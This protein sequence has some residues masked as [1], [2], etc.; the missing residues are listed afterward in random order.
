MKPNEL[1][2]YNVD[3]SQLEGV[4]ENV[5]F[6]ESIEEVQR[7][8]SNSKF[9]IVPRGGGSNIVG[10]CIPQNSI[11][12][13]LKKMNKVLEFD[14]KERSVFAEAGVTIKELNEKLKAVG[15]EFPIYC[16]DISTIGGMVARGEIGEMAMKYGPIKEWVSEIELVNGRGEIVK[17]GKA[18][19]SEVYGMEG[20][21]GVIVK[22]KLGITPIT[23][24]SASIFQTEEIEEIWT[25]AKRL[26]LE[27]EIVVL[28]LLN[29]SV[30]EIFGF[31][32]RYNLIVIF[33]SNRGK[34][35]GKNFKDLLKKIRKES[36]FL[37][38]KSYF[39]SL[40]A[41]FYFD[42]LK[43]FVF[44]L[45]NLD[46]PYLGDLGMEIIYPIF[47][48]NEDMKRVV[49][50]IQRMNGKFA[51]HGIGLKRKNL[52]NPLDK[53]ILQRVKLR[54]DPFLKINKGK[55][56]DLSGVTKEAKVE[57]IKKE[58]PRKLEIDE[59]SKT[60]EEK[61]D[62]FVKQVEKEGVQ[63]GLS[64]PDSETEKSRFSEE[65]IRPGKVTL[66]DNLDTTPQNRSKEENPKDEKSLIDSIM[67][68][69]FKDKNKDE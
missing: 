30:S 15:F 46:I 8:I 47:K 45:E 6:P 18:D 41:K 2:C 48:D 64:E 10:G 31:P 58:E 68:N 37:Y 17:I 4:A 69:K 62:K 36:Y 3:A 52:F 26:R 50:E 53:R 12:I 33:D 23:E 7:I 11:V 66:G 28:K 13:D 27:K 14:S 59:S 34:I 9:D 55:V 56:L 43:E 24:R 57:E 1:I 39:N 61:M 20:I 21:T 54:H 40:D 29:P 32:K 16:N 38:S 44:Y 42:K 35:R 65:D 25:I 19:L 60:P 22:V 5:V 63:W 51:K 67:F 49:K